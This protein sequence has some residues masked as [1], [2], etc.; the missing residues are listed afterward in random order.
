M[1]FGELWER[2]R[3]RDMDQPRAAHHA[4]PPSTQ[5]HP[6][7]GARARGNRGV[8]SPPSPWP[9]PLAP[10]RG[11]KHLLGGFVAVPLLWLRVL[12]LEMGAE[13]GENALHPSHPA[14]AAQRRRRRRG[15]CRRG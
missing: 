7:F 10:P 11:E 15:L 9:H 5:I 8:S 14:E 1:G 12:L 2:G 6:S 3:L 4:S 13:G